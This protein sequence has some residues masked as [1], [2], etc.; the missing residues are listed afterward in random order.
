MSAFKNYFWTAQLIA[1]L[2][3]TIRMG[4]EGIKE[5]IGY[6]LLWA[7]GGFLVTIPIAALIALGRLVY[8]RHHSQLSER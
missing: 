8:D 1:G 3:M 2:A 5:G 6:G 7:V 4:A